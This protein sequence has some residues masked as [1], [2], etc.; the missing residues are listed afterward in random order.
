MLLNF[1]IDCECVVSLFT[2]H[3]MPKF[4][5]SAW[6]TIHMTISVSFV[7]TILLLSFLWRVLQIKWGTQAELVKFTLLLK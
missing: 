1:A 5:N 4:E 3:S 7:K 6:F 2:D